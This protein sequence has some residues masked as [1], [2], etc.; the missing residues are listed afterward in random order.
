MRCQRQD[1]RISPT[2]C[3]N[4]PSQNPCIFLVSVLVSVEKSHTFPG[5]RGSNFTG[6]EIQ[7][8][9]YLNSGYQEKRETSLRIP[10]GYQENA[11]VLRW[12]VWARSGMD[13]GRFWGPA[14][15]SASVSNS[16][17]LSTSQV[18]G[19]HGR[20]YVPRWA[21]PQTGQAL[22]VLGTKWFRRTITRPAAACDHSGARV[23]RG[24][25]RAAPLKK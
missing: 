3:P 7:I 23:S 11:R 15:D 21:R 6:L 25:S 2:A 20:H 13:W 16:T 5:N 8:F 1:P 18:P 10:H 14:S 22:G 17:G 9:E 24:P 19:P 12:G 4:P